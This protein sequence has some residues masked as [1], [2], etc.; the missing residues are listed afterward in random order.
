MS[1]S[2]LN[3]VY[4]KAQK[5]SDNLSIKAATCAMDALAWV[6]VWAKYEMNLL[7]LEEDLNIHF[8]DGMVEAVVYWVC[9][10][11][12]DPVWRNRFQSVSRTGIVDTALRNATLR[13]KSLKMEEKD[14]LSDELLQDSH[15][16]AADSLDMA[17]EE[18]GSWIET[19]DCIEISTQT[20]TDIRKAWDK[21]LHSLRHEI[22]IR[23]IQV[24]Q[25]VT[26]A[27]I[28]FIHAANG[29]PL[30]MEGTHTG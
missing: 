1:P 19:G 9:I 16:K 2:C 10:P 6:L 3:E 4:L 8:E 14:W 30:H 20:I 18:V 27:I 7:K 29:D 28:L 25:N 26:Q 5:P 15:T 24:V 22:Q 13:Y 12:Q 21:A 17:R 11:R 23:P